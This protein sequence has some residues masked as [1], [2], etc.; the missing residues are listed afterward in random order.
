MGELEIMTS[1]NDLEQ[2]W[3][4]S[5]NHN[6]LQYEMGNVH[7]SEYHERFVQD[8]LQHRPWLDILHQFMNPNAGGFAVNPERRMLHFDIKVIHISKSGNVESI[9]ECL[10]PTEFKD[11]I[12]EEERQERSGTL[13]IAKD[14]SRAMIDSL[15]TKYELE[16]EFFASH[17]EGTETLRMGAWESP[18]VRPPPRAP[19]LLPDYLRKAPFYTV[20][21]RRP[22]HIKGGIKEVFKLRSSETNISRGAHALS[23][24]LPD[25][26]AF[27]KISVYKKPGSNIGK[28]DCLVIS[29]MLKA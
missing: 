23:N 3:P 13:I 21:Y 28:L 9:I 19:N 25:I 7:R 27:E 14:L 26:F 18:T 6:Q 20:Q 15:G 29:I 11:A 5:G 1:A 17:L 2:G 4:Q 22:Y 16:P 10:T 24:D 8:N 12:S